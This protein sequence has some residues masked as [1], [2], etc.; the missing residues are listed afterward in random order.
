MVVACEKNGKMKFNLASAINLLPIVVS[1]II[2]SYFISGRSA[3]IEARMDNVEQH[4]GELRDF[5]SKG[6]RFT[7][8]DGDDMKEWFTEFKN[9]MKQTV[10]DIR[11]DLNQL[12]LNVNSL[13]Q[14]IKRE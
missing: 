4:V 11:K 13:E 2:A 6:F 10:R 5:E 9:D 3:K 7:K 14:V 12:A 8:D 1:I